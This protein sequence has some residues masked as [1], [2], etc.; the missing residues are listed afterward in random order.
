MQ[1]RPSNSNAFPYVLFNDNMSNIVTRDINASIPHSIPPAVNGRIPNNLRPNYRQYQAMSIPSRSPTHNVI[2]ISSSDED[3]QAMPINLSRKR[4]LRDAATVVRFT[5][6]C[7]TDG[8]LSF[9]LSFHIE[10]QS[11]FEKAIVQSKS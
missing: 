4:M 9:C 1:H 5:L 10:Y 6:F 3:S 2:S 8:D 11:T 7:H